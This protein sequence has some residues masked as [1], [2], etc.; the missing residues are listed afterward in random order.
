MEPMGLHLQGSILGAAQG[1][2]QSFQ[3]T[4]LPDRGQISSPQCILGSLWLS[5]LA[6]GGRRAVFLVLWKHPF[7]EGIEGQEEV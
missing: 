4:V 2:H 7:R 6:A 3:R 5:G 1:V